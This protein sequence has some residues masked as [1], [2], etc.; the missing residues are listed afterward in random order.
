MVAVSRRRLHRVQWSS[1]VILFLAIMLLSS[2]TNS[3][4]TIDSH[5]HHAVNHV[6]PSHNDSLSIMLPRSQCGPEQTQFQLA[7]LSDMGRDLLESF[8]PRP[9]S[10]HAFRQFDFH[11]G[12]ILILVQCLLSSTANV[13]NE[14]IFKE[15]SGLQDSIYIQNSKLYFFG[16]LFNLLSLVIHRVYREK[17][18]Q[19]GFFYG[20][21]AYSVVLIFITALYGLNVAFILKFRDNMFHMLTSQLITVIVIASSIYFFAFRPSLEFFLAAPIILLAIYI[22]QI[23]R[24]KEANSSHNQSRQ[25]HRM[26]RLRQVSQHCGWLRPNCIND[27]S[28][29]IQIW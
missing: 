21:N 23:S 26:Q 14:K 3:N 24:V 18:R 19:C 7:N 13:Y 28:F 5:R 25:G 15:D 8:K 12:H 10:Q 27:F 6:I 1:L 9:H 4:L 20:H 17:I 16:A 29:I 2:Q 11:E 22:F